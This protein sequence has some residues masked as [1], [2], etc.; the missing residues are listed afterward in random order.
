MSE[1]REG[2][3][4]VEQLRFWID[5]AHRVLD[6]M[7]APRNDADLGDLP[8]TVAGRIRLIAERGLERVKAIGRSAVLDGRVEA[9]ID[10]ETP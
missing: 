9:I 4:R 6:E 1:G 2:E 7:G 5:D 8:Y 3:G 10:R